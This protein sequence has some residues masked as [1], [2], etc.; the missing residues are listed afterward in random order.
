MLTDGSGASFG[1]TTISLKPWEEREKNADEI[2]S[3]IQAKTKH[4]KDAEIQFFPPPPV[5][6]FGNA[7]GFELRLLDK[8]GSGDM[9]KLNE[10]TKNFMEAVK[11]RKEIKSIFTSFNPTFPQYLIN[12][13][14]EIASKKGITVDNAMSNLQTLM[15]SFYATNFIRFGQ[16]YKVMVQSD[17]KFRALPEDILK[18][19]VKN[20][21]GEM[22]PYSLFC[23]IE[24]I[25]GPEQLTRYNMY[26]SS[27]INGESA[28]G[29]SSGDAIKAI[30]EVAQSN[31]PNGYFYEWSGITREEIASGNQVIYIFSI[32]LIFVYLLLA[33]QYESLLLPLPVLISLPVGIF[34]SL[35]FLYLTGLENNIYAQVAMIM[36]IGLL[37][38][39]AILIIE[40]AVL[41]RKQGFSIV[42]AAK[43][44]SVARLRPILMTS[45]AFIAG[46]LPLM[47][48]SGAGAIGNKTIGTAAAG[49]MLFG[50]VF[51]ILI[52]PGLY[53]LFSKLNFKTK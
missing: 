18:L 41:K 32:C 31:L 42:E 9:Q 3:E 37:G 4:I 28:D 22:V 23:K 24:R 14:Q 34:G 15:G 49:G 33:A 45:F 35:S 26:L 50:T 38:K 40:Y 8:T 16:M 2:I 44:G 11:K 47:F 48:A 1:M 53:V 12:M 19:R 7:N 21:N 13:D 43:E 10:V 6:G 25:Y 27:N 30:E 5:P 29:Y 52:I 51:G 46:L 36:L 20:I 17:P 39:N